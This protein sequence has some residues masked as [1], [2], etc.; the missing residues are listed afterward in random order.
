MAYVYLIQ[1]VDHDFPPYADRQISTQC[2][3]AFLDKQRAL[4]FAHACS[5]RILKSRL[6]YTETWVAIDKVP[7]GNTE[8]PLLRDP[9]VFDPCDVLHTSHIVGTE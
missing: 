4:D 8:A 3:G 5:K 1:K 7:L 2:L 6:K 9:E